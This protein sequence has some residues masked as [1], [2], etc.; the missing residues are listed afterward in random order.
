MSNATIALM[1]RPGGERERQVRGQR[2]RRGG[3]R[4]RQRGRDGDGVERQPGGRQ[5]RRV[6]EEDVAHRQE[7]RDAGAHLGGHARPRG[8]SHARQALMFSSSS[9]ATLGRQGCSPT[10]RDTSRTPSSRPATR[11]SPSSWRSRPCSRRSRPSWCCRSPASRSRTG[12]S[13]SCPALAASTLGAVLG[14]LAAVRDRTA[15]RPPRRAAPAPAAA[16]HR[17]RH[18]P[19]R[20]LVRPPRGGD[21]PASAGS[22]R[23]SA[24]SSRCPPGCRRCR[25]RTFLA[26]TDRGRAAVERGAA[27]RRRAA[28]CAVRPRGGLRRARSRTAVVAVVGVACV[29]GVVWLRR[30]AVRALTGSAPCGCWWSRTSRG[31]R[32]WSSGRCA[33][34]ARPST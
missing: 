6:D 18:R 25:S 16:D 8:Q 2:H 32:R 12:R 24:A 4:G 21:R 27:R 14:A 30:R 3:D 33:R 31:W 17:A 19:R 15:R 23:A 13:P 20:P 29:A 5:D 11:G 1:P 26:A 22:S 7:R 9:V 34:R 28:R 10:C